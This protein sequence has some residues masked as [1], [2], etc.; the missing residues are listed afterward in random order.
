MKCMCPL[1][2]SA[3]GHQA[4]ASELPVWAASWQ[5]L[6][7]GQLQGG[8]EGEALRALNRSPGLPQA[9]TLPWMTSME[10]LF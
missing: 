5:M 1:A 10:F 6:G 2:I 4:T 9:K 8:K 7:Q 3:R